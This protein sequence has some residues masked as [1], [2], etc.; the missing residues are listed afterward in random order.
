MA[1]AA[2]YENCWNELLKASR[3][4]QLQPDIQQLLSHVCRTS[5]ELLAFDLSA[6][7]LLERSG[8]TEQVCWPAAPGPD[9]SSADTR[10]EIA[11]NVIHT[12][13]S[14][15]VQRSKQNRASTIVC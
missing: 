15:F 7:F 8:I 10:L 5:S 1:D 2:F 9:C 12:G 3:A 14:T 4:W 6:V 11:T 13:R